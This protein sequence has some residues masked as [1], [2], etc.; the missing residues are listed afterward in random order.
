MPHVVLPFWTDCYE[1]ASRVEMLGIGIKGCQKYQPVF[2]ASE[3]SQRL[4]RVINGKDAEQ[5]KSKALEL[6][7][8]CKQHGSGPAKAAEGILKLATELNILAA[9]G[10]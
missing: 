6:A 9:K 2:Q 1:Y 3:L 5:M 7:W 8:V 4:L 10:A